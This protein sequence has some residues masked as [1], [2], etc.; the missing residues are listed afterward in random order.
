MLEELR[1]LPVTQFKIA[2]SD[3]GLLLINW[4]RWTWMEITLLSF[5]YF[6]SL[7]LTK[8]FLASIFS[9]T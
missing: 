7:S 4:S 6:N 1:N 8:V 5:H 2:K 9:L 3:I